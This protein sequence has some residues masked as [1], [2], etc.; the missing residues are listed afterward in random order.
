MCKGLYWLAKTPAVRAVADSG[1]VA[2][3]AVH[4]VTCV[5]CK[6]IVSPVLARLGSAACHSCRSGHAV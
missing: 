3:P 1:R 4:L 6:A 5:Y 2:T